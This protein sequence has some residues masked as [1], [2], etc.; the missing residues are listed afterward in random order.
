MN[1][2]IIIRDLEV[3]ALIGTLPHERRTRQ[4]L[5]F[6][7]EVFT[8]FSHAGRSDDLADAVDYTRIEAAVKNLAEHSDFRLLEKLGDEAVRLILGFAGVTETILSIDKPGAPRF[9]RS[10]GIKMH[11][12][13]Q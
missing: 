8:D 12:K 2:S 13:K 10:I 9:A 4:K 11:R 6:N 1:D 7:L 3:M 5:I